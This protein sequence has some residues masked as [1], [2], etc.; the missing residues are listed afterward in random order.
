VRNDRGDQEVTI[1]VHVDLGS[2]RRDAPSGGDPRTFVAAR[3][4][5]RGFAGGVETAHLHRD[6]GDPGQTQHQHRDQCGDP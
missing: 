6:G 1:A 2:A 4:L 3:G 5:S